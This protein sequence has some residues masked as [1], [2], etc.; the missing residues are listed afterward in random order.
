MRRV[1][2]QILY[3]RF[4]QEQQLVHK[5]FQRLD[6]FDHLGEQLAILR[7]VLVGGQDHLHAASNR[8]ERRTQ[9]VGRVGHDAAVL[10]DVL[11]IRPSK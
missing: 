6:L 3:F 4:G 7:A 1:Q 11:R 10:A 8:G 2:P 9:L 5:R